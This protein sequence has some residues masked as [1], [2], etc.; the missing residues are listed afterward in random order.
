MIQIS[1][2]TSI[3]RSTSPFLNFAIIPKSLYN[4][5]IYNQYTTSLTHTPYPKENHTKQL[6][7]RF[8]KF[9]QLPL[10]ARK[11]LV[12]LVLMLAQGTVVL[13]NARKSSSGR[14]RLVAATANMSTSSDTHDI[15][16]S[17]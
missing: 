7:L 13:R 14:S 16:P 1:L 11:Y 8:S 3:S 9:F 2:Q 15:L 5:V 6:H 12:K 10:N 17:E 4:P